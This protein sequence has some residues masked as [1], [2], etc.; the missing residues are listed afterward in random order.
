[1]LPILASLLT[2]GLGKILGGVASKACGIVSELVEDKDLATQINARLTEQIIATDISKF[3]AQITAQRDVLVAEIKG[4][5][6]L[7]RNWRPMVMMMFASIICNNYIVFPYLGMWTDKVTELE[8]PPFMWEC[9]KL[10]L[11]GYIVGRSAEKIAA[12]SGIKGILKKIT[13]GD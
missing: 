3:T 9:I 2:S 4:E 6:W 5:S 1:M 7:Q 8:L 11:S 10:G 12:G 13:S